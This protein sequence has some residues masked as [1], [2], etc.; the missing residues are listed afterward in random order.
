MVGIGGPGREAVL[1]I[2]GAEGDGSDQEG[3]AAWGT[4]V[5]A[6]GAGE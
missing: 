6:K 1:V 2:G 5:E 4:W 3:L